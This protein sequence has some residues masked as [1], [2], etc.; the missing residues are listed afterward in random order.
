MFQHLVVPVDGSAVAASVIPMAIEFAK[1][2]DGH[3]DVVTSID[4]SGNRKTS[5]ARLSAALREVSDP[6]VEIRTHELVAESPGLG[7]ADFVES[8]SGSM[9]MM[10]SHGHGRSAAVLGSATDDV[11][12]RTFGPVIVVGPQVDRA[13]PRLD[14][15]YVVGVDGSHRSETLLPFVEAW[16]IEFG[17]VPWIVEAV[18]SSRGGDP[19]VWRSTY[20]DRLAGDLRERTGHRI[21]AKVVYGSRPADAIVGF[22][23]ERRC[24][25]IFAT[26]HGR[27]GLRR[28]RSGSVAAEIVRNAHCPV[29]L[30]RPPNVEP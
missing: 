6:D 16:A 1:A 29:V 17:G 12:R 5:A 25:L 9:V 4:A 2:V 30:S 24:S 3:V 15:E 8:S 23:A 11:L 26:T 13:G 18:A 28:L 10:S 14:G 21:E 27:T 19:E 7:I 22:A 20:P